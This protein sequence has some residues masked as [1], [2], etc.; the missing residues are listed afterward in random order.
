M[1]NIILDDLE[2]KNKKNQSSQFFCRA[3]ADVLC[4]DKVRIGYARA[5]SMTDKL[6]D[7]H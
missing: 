7:G 2:K 6:H 4:G 3:E 5:H 1:Y